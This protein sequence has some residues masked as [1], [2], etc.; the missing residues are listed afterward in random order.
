[1]LCK[2]NIKQKYLYSK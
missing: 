2:L 1:M